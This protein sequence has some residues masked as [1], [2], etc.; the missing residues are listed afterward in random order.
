MAND[1]ELTDGEKHLLER[2]EM[3]ED[4]HQQWKFEQAR[5]QPSYTERK[6]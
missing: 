4:A 6:R 2:G 5:S 1:H 3:D